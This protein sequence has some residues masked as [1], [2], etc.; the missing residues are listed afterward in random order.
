[1][2]A[3]KFTNRLEELSWLQQ[4]TMVMLDFDHVPGPRYGWAI[5]E[6]T[7][8]A[9]KLF[10]SFGF[11]LFLSG[12]LCHSL[13]AE[14][15]W[16]TEAGGAQQAA[17]IL[18]ARTDD[19]ELLRRSRAWYVLSQDYE[20][21][22]LLGLPQRL[23]KTTS[24]RDE[25]MWQGVDDGLT[26]KLVVERDR[27]ADGQIVVGFFSDF[28]W[29]LADP[30]QV[31]SLDGEGHQFVCRV[32]RLRPGKYW[33]GAMV[34]GPPQPQAL[35]V[36]RTWP[37]PIEVAADK[38]TVV[39]LRVSPQFRGAGVPGGQLL[40]AEVFAGEWPKMDPARLI[41][42]RTVDRAGAVLPFCSVTFFEMDAND[43]G[44]LTGLWG[45]GTDDQGYCYCDRL[46]GPIRIL[47][48]RFD[49]S[50]DR[51]A[52]WSR[53]RSQS[54]LRELADSKHVTFVCDDFLTGTGRIHGRVS[55]SAGQPL[56]GY[57][58]TIDRVDKGADR[59]T[60]EYRSQRV[61]FPVMDV[62]GRFAIENLPPG[63]YEV[64]HAIDFDRMRHVFLEGNKPR[65]HLGDEPAAEAR[66][67][68]ELEARELRCGRA[69]FE[70]GSPVT[71]GGWHA[72]LGAHGYTLESDGSF[73][74]YLSK[75]ERQGLPAN[76]KEPIEFRSRGPDR[77]D[78][79]IATTDRSL[80]DL[81]LDPLRPTEVVL[82]Q[83]AKKAGQ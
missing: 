14:P 19:V 29:W 4:Q 70:D 61:N 68:I 66:L 8:E 63:D 2:L 81:S 65:V 54:Q 41:T 83:P 64:I 60:G 43:H 47:T 48:T 67:D 77:H 22:L 1:L 76:G 62:E 46:R 74:V 59:A 32:D 10:V 18:A 7:M 82:K 27:G 12:V 49:V 40:E 20:S 25:P 75:R 11:A 58:L 6:P 34:G 16:S 45:F 17:T 15:A 50:P 69:V 52:L 36:H 57:F 55:D 53:L 3:T 33:I 71:G 5:K 72:R 26:V 35:G 28:R 42:L 38:S 21:G 30:V 78:E 44:N 37:A 51:L 56:T 13:A 80:D 9:A 39:E 24:R 79:K 31:R 23:G 73:R